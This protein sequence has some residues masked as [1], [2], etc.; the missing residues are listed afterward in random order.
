MV[1]TILFFILTVIAITLL[2]NG[3]FNLKYRKQNKDE[4]MMNAL[5]I[6]E[7]GLL[8]MIAFWWF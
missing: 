6:F 2:Y 4:V 3:V 7:A 8:M 1:T 5:Q